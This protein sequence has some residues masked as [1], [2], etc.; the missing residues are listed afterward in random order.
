[1]NFEEKLKTIE[2]IVTEMESDS[3]TLDSSMEL[4]EKGRRLLQECQ[5]YLAQARGKIQVLRDGQ[6]HPY[7][8]ETTTTAQEERHE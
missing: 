3:I 4:Y 2:A 6:L 7:A 8:P 5:D 1:M